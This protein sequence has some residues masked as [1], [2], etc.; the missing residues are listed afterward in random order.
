MKFNGDKLQ[1]TVLGSSH[2]PAV[3]AVIEGLPAGIPIDME[4]L[5]ELMARRAPGRMALTSTRHETD[6]VEF[7]SGLNNG[8]TCGAPLHL[9][10]RN[11]DARSTD[12]EAI[13]DIPR[14]S[15]AD[16]PARIKYG[17]DWDGRGG[18][19]FSARMT[20]PLCAAGGI[21]LQ[22]LASRSV[23]VGAHLAAVGSVKDEAFDAM[24]VGKAQ[25]ERIL[26]NGFP[27]LDAEKGKEMQQ[28]I[29]AALEAQDSV[30]GIVEC[31]ATG[32]PAGLGGPLF[33]GVE[34]RLSAALFAVPAVRGVE[35]G[36]G[37]AAA[38]M[39]GSRHNDPYGIREGRITPLSNNA[40]GI[41][42]GMT[43]GMPL[44]VRA[45]FKP[46]PSIGQA[47]HSVDM[48]RMEE[49]ELRITGRHDACVA[50]RAV[51]VVEAVTAL[52][53]LDLML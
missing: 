2:G 46:T 12:Y 25:F 42:G 43:T 47:Q 15:H 14:P 48:R 40:G 49:V 28:E 23:Y 31:A 22:I 44:I 16:Y 20:A 53:L 50:T 26:A 24:T 39:N 10:I 27:V 3:G 33:E 34:S 52:V 9:S 6:E 36:C 8:V 18:G 21:A 32:L 29:A 1:V 30:G 13:R 38:Q 41:L 19:Q 11:K 7:V 5:A 4:Q 45:A 35:F 17:E 37:F 51:P